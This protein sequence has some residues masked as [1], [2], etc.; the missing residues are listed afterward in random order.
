HKELCGQG[1][2]GQVQATDTQ[3]GD[4]KGHAYQG[5]EHAAQQDLQDQ[6]Q[7]RNTDTKVPGGIRTHSHESTRTDG[8]LAAIAHQNVQA[9]RCQRQDQKGDQNSLQEVVG[10]HGWHQQECHQQQTQHH[11]AILADGKNLLVSPIAAFE[12]TIFAVNHID[13]TSDAIN[14]LL[15]EQT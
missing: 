10:C 5:G 8:N 4:T 3:A 1:R 7:L 12:L 2:D 13:S 11:I 14:N 6:W 9:N 15:A